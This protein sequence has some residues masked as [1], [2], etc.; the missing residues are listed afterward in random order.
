M[1][2]TSGGYASMIG[3]LLKLV[4]VVV[5]LAVAA[6]FFLGY[7]L[8]ADG[9]EAPASARQPAPSIDTDKARQT[10]AAIGEKVAAGAAEAEQA[11]GEAALTAKIKSK[12]ALDDTVKALA[13]DV[14]TQGGMV[15]LSGFVTSPF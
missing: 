7:R 6:A 12:M 15:T 1:L 8:G 11:L 10:G 14:D 3:A 13:I 5:I 4:L 2:E 9:I